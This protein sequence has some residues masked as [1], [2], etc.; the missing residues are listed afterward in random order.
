MIAFFVQIS[1]FI[2]LINRDTHLTKW[3]NQISGMIAEMI[4]VGINRETV[5]PPEKLETVQE[6]ARTVS[7][8]DN[9]LTNGIK[10]HTSKCLSVVFVN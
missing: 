8:R 9:Q 7:S 5:P 1:Q 6:I 4:F 2:G 3:N 10:S